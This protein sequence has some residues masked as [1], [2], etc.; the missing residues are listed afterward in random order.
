MARSSAKRLTDIRKKRTWAKQE[1]EGL[2]LSNAQPKEGVKGK[3][4]KPKSPYVL[5]ATRV[6]HLPECTT[7]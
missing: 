6:K 5:H 7:E 2:H 1:G 4:H 3:E